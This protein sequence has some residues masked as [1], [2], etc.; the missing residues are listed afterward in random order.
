MEKLKKPLEI[1][2]DVTG[3]GLNAAYLAAYLEDKYKK[4]FTIYDAKKS[5]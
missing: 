1:L 4:T 2:Q 3:E 5:W